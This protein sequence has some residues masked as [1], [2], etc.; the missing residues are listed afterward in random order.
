MS[1]ALSQVRAIAISYATVLHPTPT[2]LF[3]PAHH[4]GASIIEQLWKNWGKDEGGLRGN[5]VDLYNIN[6]PMIEGLLCEDGLKIVT[7]TVWR[8]SYG[9]LFKPIA[10]APRLDAVSTVGPD[11]TLDS[12]EPLIA[13]ST[14]QFKFS[15]DMGPLINPPPSSV[16]VGS[17]GW[18]IQQGK[19][20]V[21][22]LRASFGEPFQD[23]MLSA[24]DRLWHMKL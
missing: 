18:A 23:R 4:L 14:L 1:A 9:R 24:E 17:D 22:P 16:P 6:I 21:T 7:T 15:P 8:N 11:A 20:S 19:V 12:P 10:A 3:K 13:K 2:N 5:E